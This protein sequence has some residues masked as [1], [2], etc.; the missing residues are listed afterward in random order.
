MATTAKASSP[1]P[2]VAANALE[3]RPLKGLRVDWRSTISGTL[4][5][6][7]TDQ[8]KGQ[9]PLPLETPPLPG[10]VPNQ[11]AEWARQGVQVVMRP[12]P[13]LS[14]VG[15]D[16]I[17]ADIHL[18]IPTGCA[19]ATRRRRDIDKVLTVQQLC[20]Y[21]LLARCWQ[22]IHCKGCHHLGSTYGEPSLL[23]GD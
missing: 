4:R 2:P 18:Q 10:M 8:E 9:D 16:W 19:T 3:G 14:D 22:G 7:L 6:P 5:L 21:F 15:P 23:R 17:I 20:S 11:A 12:W 13:W 1:A